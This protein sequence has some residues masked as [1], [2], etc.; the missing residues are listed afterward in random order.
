[1]KKT[2]LP[3]FLFEEL[4]DLE[5]LSP[6]EMDKFLLSLGKYCKSVGKDFG[7]ICK[8]L[9][10]EIPIW[11][12]FYSAEQIESLKKA[13]EKRWASDPD[14]KFE[15][16]SEG[17]IDVE[18]NF[19]GHSGGF[20]GD[21][22]GL[23]FGTVVGNFDLSGC[24][25]KSLKGCPK[26]VSGDFNISNNRD[27]KS[28]EGSPEYIKGYYRAER[29]GIENLEGC[30]PQLTDLVLDDNQNLISLKGSPKKV[31]NISL[32]RCYNL[33]SLEGGPEELTARFTANDNYQLKSLI[34]APGP[35]EMG[36]S[37]YFD[38]CPSLFTLEGLPLEGKEPFVSC[39][40]CGLKPDILKRSYRV[41]RK[42]GS[43]VIAHMSMF[44]DENFIKTGKAPKD[45]IR[46][47]LT[48]EIIKKEMEQNKG[49][50][51]LGIKDYLDDFR[52]QK[53]LKGIEI[54]KE[55]KEKIVL[56]SDLG[57]IGI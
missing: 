55:T 24:D 30:T 2:I 26:N 17:I 43:W 39:S 33:E 31:R 44:T 18:G 10:I 45:P 40:K 54:P 50:F 53:L 57:D 28:L 5:K 1:M 49:A 19:R 8:E 51:T 23:K 12:K 29:T 41:A 38:N 16:N 25:L 4:Q 34:G 9:D 56:L 20:R 7:K 42:Y 6:E 52:V 13:L 48:P 46:A 37:Y 21:L 47:R 3:F 32:T 22:K 14:P 11:E 27:L 15:I 35:S 36:V